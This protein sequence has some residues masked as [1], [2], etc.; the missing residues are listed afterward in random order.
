MSGTNRM[1]RCRKWI[2]GL[3]ARAAGDDQRQAGVIGEKLR[4]PSAERSVAPEYEN[5]ESLLIDGQ[6]AHHHAARA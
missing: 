3:R 2:L 1:S 4:Q 6:S 5:L